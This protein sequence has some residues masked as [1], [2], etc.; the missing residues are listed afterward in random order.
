MNN[1]LKLMFLFSFLG[2]TFGISGSL[3]NK[4]DY[5]C[6]KVA[7]SYSS[8][9]SA[10]NN[11]SNSHFQ[12]QYESDVQEF[13]YIKAILLSQGLQEQNAMKVKNIVSR[14]FPYALVPLNDTV[15][16]QDFG[17]PVTKEISELFTQLLVSDSYKDHW[18]CACIVI[19]GF[20][21]LKPTQEDVQII[22]KALS[23]CGF[24]FRNGKVY[25]SHK[26]NEIYIIPLNSYDDPIVWLIK[27]RR[28]VY[29]RASCLN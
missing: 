5:L 10:N 20:T 14:N 29:Q 11:P 2:S 17:I 27:L 8:Y 26:Q 6:S 23:K 15:S 13:M 16:N 25:Q 19:C 24:Y 18:Q 21:G 28:Y 7:S 3:E 12:Q 4:M 9:M 22:D 1:N